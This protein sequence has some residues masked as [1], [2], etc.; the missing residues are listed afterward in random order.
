MKDFISI[1]EN[2]VVASTQTGIATTD[3]FENIKGKVLYN[4]LKQLPYGNKD[5]SHFLRT[6]LITNDGRCMPRNDANTYNMANLIVI[7]CDKRIDEEGYEIE[8]APDPL[9]VHQTL[10]IMGIGH[11]LYGSY[12][13]Y[14][15]QKGNRYRIILATDKPYG[16]NQ[17]PAT[18][19][20]MIISLNQNLKGHLLAYAKE[21]N[22]FAQGWYYPRKPFG[23]NVELL[24]FEYLDGLP[25]KGANFQNIPPT[26][27]TDPKKKHGLSDQNSP[28]QAFN[29]QHQLTTLLSQYGYKRKLVTSTQEKWLSPESSSGIAGI[30]VRDDKFFSHHNDPFNDGYWHDAFDLVRVREG[31]SL[32]DAIAKAAQE[33]IAIDDSAIYEH[34]KKPVNR[35][36]KNNPP[37]QLPESRPSVM[38]FQAE[39]LPEAIRD[40]VYD[41]ADRQQS[42]P[43]FVAVAAIVGLSGL[44][45]RKASICP[46]Q[47]DDWTVTP[48]QWGAI[49]GRPSAM[50]SPSMKEA[51]KPLR[52]F[53][54][55]S[56]QEFE[57]NLQNYEEE[58]QLIELEK[59]TA[60]IKAKN[61]LKKDDRESAK[62]ALKISES[63]F[64]PTRKRRVVNDATVEKL[65]E[66][67]KENS[68]G[69][70][71]VRDEL[72]GWL[73]KLN[74]EE[75]QTDR[76]FYL[77]CFDGNGY[78]SYDRIG[79]GTIVI[80]N[81]TLSIIG[82]I[83]PSKI[84]TL[85]R[86]AIRGTADDGLIQRF[87]LAIWPDN[88]GCWEWIDRA[89]NQQAK[90]KYNAVFEMLHKLNFNTVDDEPRLF[91]FTN[92]AQNLFITWMKEIQEAARDSDIHPA[93]ES[94]MLKMPQ[95]IAGL[96]LL[97]EVIDGGREAVGATSTARAL[98]WADY[99]LSHAK[100]LYS[101]AMNHSL[102][103]AKLILER[104]SKLDNPF[105][106]RAI[107]RKGWSGLNRIED[108][109]D[110]L[111]WLIDY[112]YIVAETVASV[113]TNGRPKVVYHWID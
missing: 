59:Q 46:K 44:L 32:K 39:M 77:E 83:Q 69:L 43:D 23:S 75:H 89:P 34:N 41:V 16:R 37:R 81:C 3:R 26:N 73:A 80:P 85:V 4:L 14:A 42:L 53:D 30:T 72:S 36:I 58:C 9:A 7:D 38:P 40:Y 17:L 1:L 95:T 96:A 101:L 86:D 35:Q 66:L 24:Y 22:V 67:L 104:K 12:S 79:R 19:E 108:V 84:A 45:G 33:S 93:L 51:I 5:G 18:V 25:I 106:A 65:G 63:S 91:R 20:K 62:E 92:E 113:D 27:H 61:A 94:H 48:N 107:H 87:Q 31:L 109:Y 57:E 11:I 47:L 99:L 10:K 103:G 64:M 13:H 28:I 2:T 78:Y 49:I 71:L 111:N 52:Q 97:F 105:S 88:V 110:A 8:G 74:K 21:N 29:E 15:G 68:N 82:G 112:G 70:I 50:K 102:N 6:S 60:K 55:D 98:D 54:V 90:E 100:R 56:T 76:A